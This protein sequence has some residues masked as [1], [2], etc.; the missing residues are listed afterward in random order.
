MLTM[1]KQPVNE[2]RQKVW[3]HAV[4]K[5]RKDFKKPKHFKVFSNHFLEEKANKCNPD[6]TLLSKIL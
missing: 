1:E 3:T 2:E 6:P 4:S 5:G